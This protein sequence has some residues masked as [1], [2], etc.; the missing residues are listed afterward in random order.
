MIFWAKSNEREI[1]NF[2][3]KLA[4]AIMLVISSVTGLGIYLGQARVSANAERDLRQKFQAELSGL[5][6]LREL[7]NAALAERCRVLAEKPRIHAALEDNAL[8]LLYP[9]AKDELQDL[10]KEG[11]S[12]EQ[13]TSSLH[14]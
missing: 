14:A 3:T 4:I 8:D 9:S 11:A 6:K 10:I 12:S 7:R 13:A 1:T 5:D 2:R